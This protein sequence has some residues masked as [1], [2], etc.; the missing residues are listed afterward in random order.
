MHPAGTSDTPNIKDRLT[1]GAG[2]LTATRV[3]VNLITFANTLLVARLLVPEDFGL[4][5]IATTITAIIASITELSLSSALVQHKEL[6]D[7]H[8]D[9]AW[10]LNFLRNAILALL[11]C[12]LAVPVARLYGDPRL[13]PILLVI[14]AATL[15]GGAFNPKLVVLTKELI[16]WQEFVI[17][18]SQKVVALI[19]VTLVAFIFRSYWALVAGTVATQIWAT[20]LS[21]LLIPYRP[22]MRFSRIAELL[23]FSIWI[24]LSGAVNTLNWKFDQLV[25][26]YFLGSTPLGYY[27]V[28]DNLAVLPTRESTAPLAQT[29]FPAFVLLSHDTERL[30]NAYQRAQSLLLAVAL[31]LGLGF[32]LIA[33]PLVRLTLGAK[34]LPAVIVIQILGGMSALHMLSST[35]NPLALAIGKTQALFKRDLLNFG[36]RLPLIVIGMVTGGLVGIVY[37]RCISGTA[38]IAINMA[39]VRRLL[40]LSFREQFAVN[41]RTLMSVGVMVLGVFLVGRALGDADGQLQLAVKVASM[42]TG[43]AVIYILSLFVLWHVARRPAGFENE[44]VTLADRA[45]RRARDQIRKL[46]GMAT[47]SGTNRATGPWVSPEE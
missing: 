45:F 33:E 28:G 37:A 29:L 36:L 22:R 3:L 16:F 14:G 26:G 20:L 17:G 34:W 41:L 1:K 38:S 11:I 35:L 23:S 39:M 4:V 19:V 31:P 5:A 42:I 2:W 25:I 24:T 40:G 7:E 46:L 18:V 43:G 10:T 44:A 27:T 9:A 13:V 12:V 47:A 32:S 15:L 6:H 21:Y 8:F 30:R